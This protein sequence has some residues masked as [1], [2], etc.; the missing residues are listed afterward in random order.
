MQTF[1]DCELDFFRD[2]LIA[3]VDVGAFVSALLAAIKEEHNVLKV[4]LVDQ[5]SHHFPDACEGIHHDEE[6]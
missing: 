5:I 4:L 1:D 3:I 2:V 6:S